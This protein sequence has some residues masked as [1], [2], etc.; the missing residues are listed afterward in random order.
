MFIT[1]LARWIGALKLYNNF[2]VM[3]ILVCHKCETAQP[4]GWEAR[5]VGGSETC[6]VILS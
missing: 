3:S 6:T 2:N 4:G 1:L 5:R